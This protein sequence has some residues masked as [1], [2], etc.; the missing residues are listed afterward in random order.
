MRSGSLPVPGYPSAVSRASWSRCGRYRYSLIRSWEPGRPRLCVCMLNPSTADEHANDPTVRRSVGFALDLGFG[1]IEVVNCFALRA[2][3]PRALAADPFPVA[4]GGSRANDRAIERAVARADTAVAAW[5]NH[6]AL[7]GRDRRVRALL[8][9]GAM[10]FGV[11]ASGQP[12]HPLY[13][14]AGTPLRPLSSPS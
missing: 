2:T 1:S 13:L 8:P 5:G 9:G 10:A 14:S 7:N 3:D 4:P 12:R 6:A 11:T